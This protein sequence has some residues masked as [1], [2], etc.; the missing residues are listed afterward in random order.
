MLL[1]PKYVHFSIIHHLSHHSPLKIP[2]ATP[3]LSRIQCEMNRRE[4]N[5]MGWEEKKVKGKRNSVRTRMTSALDMCQ[6]LSN[7][8]SFTQTGN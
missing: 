8:Y 7:F 5:G 6:T 2:F 3:L 4:V 1:C